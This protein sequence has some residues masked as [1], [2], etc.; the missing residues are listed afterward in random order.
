MTVG[1]DKL[2]EMYRDMWRMRTLENRLEENHKK[3]LVPG[4]FH[5]GVGQEASLVGCA[6]ALEKTDYF[7]PDHR[8]HGLILIAG[9][10]GERQPGQQCH[11]GLYC[12]HG[13][14]AGLCGET[15]KGR[16]GV[17]CLSR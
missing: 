6:H 13:I 15:A 4:F 11:P 7:F 8:S 5:S 10:P 3:G 16:P 12:G 17:G 1:N 2:L 14:G 9:T